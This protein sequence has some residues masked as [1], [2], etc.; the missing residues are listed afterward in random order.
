MLEARL[1]SGDHPAAQVRTEKM[2]ELV[3][4]M[5]ERKSELRSFLARSKSESEREEEEVKVEE[6]LGDHPEDLRPADFHSELSR[7]S[8][9][10]SFE[11]LL[12]GTLPK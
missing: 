6:Q 7:V 4:E 5:N 12:E 9:D 1:S 11:N 3:Q 2:N 10:H 8:A